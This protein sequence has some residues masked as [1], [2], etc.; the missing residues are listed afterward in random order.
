[1]HGVAYVI[2]P[3]ESAPLQRALNEALAPFQRGGLEEFS[4]E[5]LAFDDVTGHLWKLHAES[6]ALNLE[7]ASVVVCGGNPAMVADLDFDA[8]REFMEIVGADSGADVS[9]TLSP[10]SRR[11]CIASRNGRSEIRSRAATGAGSIRLDAGT[12]GISAAASTG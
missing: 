3:T 6:I 11:S 7:S 12:G 9:R 8:L 4:L 5:K 10:T 2:L 1:M